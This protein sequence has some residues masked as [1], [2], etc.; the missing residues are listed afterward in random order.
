MPGS[1]SAHSYAIAIDINA[2][3]NEIGTDG[4]MSNELAL[5]FTSSGLTWGKDFHRKDPMHFSLGW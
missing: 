3:T 1:I 5:C 2:S 4:D